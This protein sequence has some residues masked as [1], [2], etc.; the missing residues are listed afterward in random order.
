M[1]SF[2]SLIAVFLRLG[3]FKM[4]G[5]Q[6]PEFPSWHIGWGTLEDEVHLK[7][8]K[9]EKNSNMAICWRS[10]NIPRV[11]MGLNSRPTS[12]QSCLLSLVLFFLRPPLFLTS[13]LHLN[14]SFPFLF[15]FVNYCPSAT[16]RRRPNP[17]Q[18]FFKNAPKGMINIKMRP[19]FN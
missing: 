10:H 1:D 8:A 7:F 18:N 17:C 4:A 14:F 15:F 12:S 5:L 3:S 16:F 2:A 11:I 19:A 6:H 13:P 9:I